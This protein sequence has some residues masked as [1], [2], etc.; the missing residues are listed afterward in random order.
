MAVFSYAAAVGGTC[1]EIYSLRLRGGTCAPPN[2][3]VVVPRPR[4]I[5][6]AEH[7]SA[8]PFRRPLVGA[9]NHW[10]LCIPQSVRCAA[11]QQAG[12][13]AR[14]P[15][16]VMPPLRKGAKRRTRPCTSSDADHWSALASRKPHFAQVSI[17]IPG[18]NGYNSSLLKIFCV[19]MA[20]LRPW[21][22]E[23]MASHGTSKN[24]R[25]LCR[26]RCL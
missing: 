18:R 24:L 23:R 21:H 7:C 10:P 25:N 20:R 6:S 26:A 1:R 13:F 9:T 4:A 22:K 3:F 17:E 8:F 15:R 5:R 16:V 19:P 11:R 12:T 14:F 2:L